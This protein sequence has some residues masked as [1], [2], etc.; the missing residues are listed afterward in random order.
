MTDAASRP[1]LIILSN[2]LRSARTQRGLSL[3]RLARM[4]DLHP[5]L[6]SAFELGRRAP[7]D[8]TVAHILGVLQSPKI[9]RNHLVDLARRAREC[10]FIDHTGRAGDILHVTYEQQSK[11]VFVWSPWLIPDALQTTEYACALRK[12]GPFEIDDVTV[13]PLARTVQQLASSDASGLR[14]TFLIGEAATRSGVCSSDELRDQVNAVAAVTRHP[15][16]SV[17]LVPA[18]GYAPGLLEPFTLYEDN[19]GAVA[20]AVRHHLGAVFLTCEAALETY[21]KIAQSLKGRA[22]DTWP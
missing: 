3:R 7:E 10:D 4:A 6:L 8:T 12:G 22:A 13:R 1:A 18:A 20:V 11:H 14:Y 15:R 21:P 5:S 17:R 16:V 19:A 9:M 2:A